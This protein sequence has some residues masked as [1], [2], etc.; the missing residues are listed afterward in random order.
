MD[1]IS[2]EIIWARKKK[3]S[4]AYK[5]SKPHFHN[6]FEIF[7]LSNG[8]CTLQMNDDTYVMKKGDLAIIPAGINHCTAYSKDFENERIVV[9]FKKEHINILIETY[10][11]DFFKKFLNKNVF[12]FTNKKQSHIENIINKLITEIEEPDNLSSEYKNLLLFEF[13]LELVRVQNIS[14]DIYKPIDLDNKSIQNAIDFIYENYDK[15]ITLDDIAEMLHLNKSYLSKKF[16]QVS[17]FGFKEYLTYVRIKNAEK[18][19]LDSDYSI[20]TIA[21]KCGFT[22]SNYFGDIFKKINGTSPMN[23]RKNFLTLK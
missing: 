11:T 15:E 19:L 8:E 9:D 1:K 13:V 17:G 5:M 16:K 18:F 4:K 10:G 6:Y 22:D 3:L 7:Y 12:T 20:T 23:F 21:T 2:D 14:N